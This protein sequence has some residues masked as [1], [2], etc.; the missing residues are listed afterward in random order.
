MPD[1]EGPQINMSSIKVSGI[2]GLGMIAVC[3]LM[4]YTLLEI[5]WFLFVSLA[6]GIIGA[7][8]LIAYRRW[9]RPEP[10]HGPTLMVNTTTTQVPKNEPSR[11]ERTVTLSPVA[12]SK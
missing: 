12:L 9:V 2:G 6:G 7:M 8:A 10:P 1:L 11:I 5:R 4:A 3:G